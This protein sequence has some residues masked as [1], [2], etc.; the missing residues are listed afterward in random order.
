MPIPSKFEGY[1]LVQDHEEFRIG[2]F[3][4][5]GKYKEFP[6]NHFNIRSWCVVTANTAPMVPGQTFCDRH[7]VSPGTFTVIR[8]SSNW[9]RLPQRLAMSKVFATPLPLP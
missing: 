2:D 4:Y 3:Y 5:A 9:K 8:K 6:V 1:D 7:R